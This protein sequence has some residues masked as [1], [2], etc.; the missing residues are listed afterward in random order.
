[1][2]EKK[3]NLGGWFCICTFLGKK[4]KPNTWKGVLQKKD[5]ANTKEKK[6]AG[7]ESEGLPDAPLASAQV[8][9]YTPLLPWDET[10]PAH[11]VALDWTLGSGLGKRPYF[12]TAPEWIYYPQWVTP[13]L[14]L[15]RNPTFSAL[16]E[17]REARGRQKWFYK[18]RSIVFKKL[19]KRGCLPLFGRWNYHQSDQFHL[20][21]FEAKRN[22][23]ATLLQAVSAHGL[24]LKSGSPASSKYQPWAS[25]LTPGA[26]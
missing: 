12:E 17:L 2:Q 19:E 21:V 1:M 26:P 13:G 24:E 9:V 11:V 15:G 20:F 23:F 18:L 8:E 6:S 10:S 4:C 16:I 14:H 5:V 3:K 22:Y 25:S 7:R